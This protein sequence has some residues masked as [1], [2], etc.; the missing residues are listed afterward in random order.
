MSIQL[1]VRAALPRDKS[2]LYFSEI[3]LSGSQN[4]HGRYGEKKNL[5][6][7][8]NRTP[9]V[10]PHSPSLYR[11]SYPD[12][13]IKNRKFIIMINNK[14]NI[15]RHD[16]AFHKSKKTNRLHREVSFLRS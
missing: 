1:H 11:L 13:Y 4:Q 2:P 14:T 10:Q 8:G 3:K 9:A 12:F 6:P 15:L 7:A 5:V 16:I